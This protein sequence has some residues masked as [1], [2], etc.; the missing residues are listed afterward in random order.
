MKRFPFFGM[1]FFCPCLFSVGIFS[2]CTLFNKDDDDSLPALEPQ[3]SDW[4]L[5]MYADAD[6]NLNDSLWF[7]LI[8]AELGLKQIRNSDGSPKSGCPEVRVLVLWDGQSTLAAAEDRNTRLHPSAAIYELGAMDNATLEAIVSKRNKGWVFSKNARDLTAYAA[9]WLASE[10]DMADVRTLTSFLQWSEKYF[11][12]SHTVLA[13]SDHG[14]GTEYENV[15]GGVGGAHTARSL[16]T[17]DTNGSSLTLSALDVKNAITEAG[18]DIDIIWMD[19]CLQGNAET[20]YTLRG[21][22]QYLVTSANLSYSNDYEEV[23][24][25]LTTE[26]TVSSFGQAIVQEYAFRMED[27]MMSIEEDAE[28][29]SF[30]VVLTQAQY[31]LAEEKQT[32]LYQAVEALSAALLADGEAVATG[33]YESY[34]VQNAEDLSACKGMAYHGT[35]VY[36]NDLGYLCRNLLADDSATGAGVSGTTKTCAQTLMDCI[37]AVVVTSWM[38]IKGE[39]EA[40]QYLKNV[41]DFDNAVLTS[42]DGTFGLTIASQLPPST[43]EWYDLKGGADYFPLYASYSDVTGYSSQWGELMKLWHAGEY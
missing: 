37:D 17:D 1:I 33:V 22:A 16:C 18:R 41:N 19:C 40:M 12:A 21:S 9:D 38:G 23:I 27:Y 25:S 32:A 6:N 3:T 2:A 5:I 26:S 39:G 4:L 13:L 29:A 11:T 31:D 36:L 42:S 24:A 14:A 8:N 35:Y 34:L 7:D 20:A 28:R 15:S 43:I 10:P 30:D